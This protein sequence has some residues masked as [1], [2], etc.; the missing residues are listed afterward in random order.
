MRTQRSGIG[1][2]NKG[3]ITISLGRNSPAMALL[4]ERTR[5]SLYKYL[6]DLPIY[7]YFVCTGA[8]WITYCGLYVFTEG[9]GIRSEGLLAL[10]FVMLT[11][12]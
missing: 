9:F 2:G 5:G 3:K 6:H 8:Y 11:F 12:T 10:I 1:D 7:N 4:S